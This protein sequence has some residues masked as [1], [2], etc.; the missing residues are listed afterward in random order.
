M[1]INTYNEAKLVE[2]VDDIQQRSFATFV[3]VRRLKQCR[4]RDSVRL[5]GIV[6]VLDVTHRDEA[7]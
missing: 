1:Q 5:G 7:A 2:A 6:E 4:C 3:E